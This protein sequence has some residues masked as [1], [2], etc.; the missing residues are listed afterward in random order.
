MGWA[1]RLVKVTSNG[2][3]VQQNWY[4]ANSRRIAKQEL[5]N[6]QLVKTL[7]LFDGW[8]IVA[9]MNGQGQLLESYTRGVGLAG[10]IGTIVAVTHHAGSSGPPGTYYVHH[11]HR[12]DVIVTRSVGGATVGTYGYSAFGA[13]TYR[14]GSY[15]V[16]RF[17]FS[18]KELDRATGFYYYGYRFYAP[19]WQRWVNKDPIVELGGLNVYAFVLNRVLA[20]VDVDGLDIWITPGIHPVIIGDRP[21]G[22]CYTIDFGPRGDRK[23]WITNPGEY[24]FFSYSYPPQENMF[25][26]CKC[27]RIPTTTAEDRV[28]YDIARSLGANLN[29]PRYNLFKYN[30]RDFA[31]QFCGIL[32]NLRRFGTPY[33]PGHSRRNAPPPVVIIRIG[34]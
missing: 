9:V 31:A 23:Y 1:D 6:G 24:R 29:T 21:G 5:L 2:V 10:D 18:S 4:D 11:N 12:G 14:P 3:V 28:L 22:G 15:D 25:Y 34:S 8:D 16:C 17:K 7:Y 33:D 13:L 27:R 32:S 20:F 26:N 19:Q 30:C